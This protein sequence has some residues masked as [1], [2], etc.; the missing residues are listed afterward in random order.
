M[1]EDRWNPYPRIKP[2]YTGR[3]IVTLLSDPNRNRKGRVV[4]MLDY[5]RGFGFLELDDV[6]IAW[7]IAP[8]PSKRILIDD[9]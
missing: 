8:K 4:T 7:R 9:N 1:I 2:R 6:V 5:C 3:Y